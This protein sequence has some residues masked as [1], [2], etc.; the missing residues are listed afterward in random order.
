[1]RGGGG[2]KG[3]G[4]GGEGVRGGGVLEP[5]KAAGVLTEGFH[6]MRERERH[7]GRG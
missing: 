1:M 3:N 5:L 6:T 4:R 2:N 7:G